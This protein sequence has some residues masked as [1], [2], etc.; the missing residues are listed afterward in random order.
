[1]LKL[2]RLK[3]RVLGLSIRKSVGIESEFAYDCGGYG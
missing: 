1:M 2:V 3:K